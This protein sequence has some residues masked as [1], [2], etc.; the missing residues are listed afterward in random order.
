MLRVALGLLLGLLFVMG[1]VWGQDSTD[2]PADSTEAWYEWAWTPIVSRGGVQISYL[3]YQEADNVNDGVVLRLRNTN[4]VSVRYSFT[5]LFRGPRDTAQ[6][7]VEGRLDPGEV[8]TGDEDGLYWVPFQEG[9][10][11]GQVGLR[12]IRVTREEDS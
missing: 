11:V 9:K 5:I 8:K 3:F 12:G 10:A 4:D 2:A 1:P 7:A 6:A